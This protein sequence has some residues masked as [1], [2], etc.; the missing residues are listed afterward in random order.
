MIIDSISSLKTVSVDSAYIKI[1]HKMLKKLR[2][3]MRIKYK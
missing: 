2:G 3:K 1:V